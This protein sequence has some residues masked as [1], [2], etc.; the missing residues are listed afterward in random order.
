MNISS[1]V[2]YVGAAGYGYCNR[3]DTEQL[4][5]RALKEGYRSVSVPSSRVLHAGEFL[6]D[7]AVLVLCAI[8]LPFGSADSDAKRYETEVAIDYGAHEIEL[9]PSL[10][11]LQDGDYKF[12]L[13]EIRDVVEAADER[14]VKVII[15][16]RLWSETELRE[17][18]G[19]ILDSGAQFIS[20]SS[21][22]AAGFSTP[23]QISVI[24]S[25]VGE[26]FGVKAAADN[27]N[28]ASELIEAGANLVGFVE[29]PRI[30]VV[31]ANS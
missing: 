10:S 18:A 16:A 24:R 8:G 28:S 19:V 25:L 31:A 23:D 2:E 21:G 22:C 11:R 20:A 9:M 30:D 14:A 27:W 1:R 3:A 13:R 26:S 4:C 29:A 12:V 17:I 6:G 7:S 5:R 15:E